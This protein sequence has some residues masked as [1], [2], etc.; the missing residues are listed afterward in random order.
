[1]DIA[2]SKPTI[3]EKDIQAV[4]QALESRHLED[5]NLVV[6]FEEKM[7]SYIGCSY[8]IAT[9]T[10]FSA[11]HLSLIA[12]ELKKGDEVIIPSYSCPALLNPILIMGCIPVLVDTE[13]NSVCLSAIEVKRKITSKTKAI[14]VPHIFG[15]PAPVEEICSYGVPV[16][17]DCAQSV[18]GTIEGKKMGSFASI[19]VFSF[20]ASKMIT[21]GDGGMLLTDDE[22]IYNR[23]LN[24]RYYGHKKNHKYLAYNYHLTNMP[25]ALGIAQLEKLDQIIQRRKEISRQYNKA[26][27]ACSEIDCTFE[28][29]LNSAFYRYPVSINNRDFVKKELAQEGIQTGF[30]VLEGLHQLQDIGDNQFPE[31]TKNLKN[32]LSLPIY[33]DLTNL[34]VKFVI[35]KITQILEK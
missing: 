31:T 12:L 32:V 33:P 19:S 15:F 10:G 14:I 6:E 35:D 25:A 16:I 13:M 5:G 1:M 9:N 20:Y 21:T 30:G 2:H 29:R 22:E 24:Y 8:S 4:C 26:F 7:K 3:T 18:G 28:G 27:L 23:A 34:E 17:E 11:I